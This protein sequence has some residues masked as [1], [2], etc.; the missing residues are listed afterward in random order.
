MAIQ[1]YLEK[2]MLK[3][4]KR[5]GRQEY[6]WS[7]RWEDPVTGK[8][9]CESCKTGDKTAAETLQKTKWAELNL[10][11]EAPYPEP[12]L[13][14]PPKLISW[15]DC[16]NALRRALE[17]DNLRPSYVEDCLLVFEGLRRMFLD[18]TRPSLI[19]PELA[20]EWKRKR[21]ESVPTP[22]P[23]TV[24][25]DL[26]TLRAVFGKW[27]MRECGLLDTNPFANVTA[28]RC[29]DP[30]VRIVSSD[31]TEALFAWLISRWNNWRLPLV[32]LQAA[33]IVGWRSTEIAS[34][35]VEDLL[36]DGYVRVTSATS[37]TRRCKY[38]RLPQGLHD[39]LRE[40]AASG[41]AF[42]R[43]SDELR[44]L[45]MIWR[46]APHHAARIKD[47]SP[48]RFVGWLQDELQR[49]HE[50]RQKTENK[51]AVEEGRKPKTLDAFTL[52]DF[53]R[54]AITGMQMAGVTEKDASIQVGC[55]PEVMRR[56]YERLDGM[57]IAG[58]NLDR[59]IG[60]L[61]QIL[62]AGYARA[63]NETGGAT[64]NS[65]QIQTA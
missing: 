22:S 19:T 16:R 27:L 21:M 20:H 12:E 8:F 64:E 15:S 13:V 17:A 23:W 34:L 30:D 57:A 1:V 28:P 41:W 60:N 26:S 7:L 3:T 62:R 51:A 11:G 44:R 56:H 35:R 29:D 45:L 40:C 10:P 37:K 38:G 5:R 32:Y 61:P 31:E 25:G 53:R 63:E 59:Q 33:A 43:F 58:R 9:R 14:A 49:F 4:R 52:H 55:T 2:R 48:D 54:T 50:D 39:E 42:G 65:L 24:K 18:I 46:K 6:R 47:F 36:P